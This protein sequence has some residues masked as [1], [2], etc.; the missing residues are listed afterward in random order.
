GAERPAQQY[1]RRPAA[2]RRLARVEQDGLAG[3]GERVAEVRAALRAHGVGRDGHH[4]ADL[5][6]QQVVGVV[7]HAC[8]L[9][10]EVLAEEAS[11]LGPW[12][13]RA[14]SS[15]MLSASTTLRATSAVAWSFGTNWADR[16]A[17]TGKPTASSGANSSSAAEPGKATDSGS[18]PRASRAWWLVPRS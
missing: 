17:S 12:L 9:G 16:Q 13:P 7:A 4:R 10:G 5:L 8:R 14:S 6:D 1:R 11:V 15:T 2:P 18:A 3:A